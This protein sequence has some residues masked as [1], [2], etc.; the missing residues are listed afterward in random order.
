MSLDAIVL[1]HPPTR[2]DHSIQRTMSHRIAL[3]NR[4]SIPLLLDFIEEVLGEMVFPLFTKMCQYSVFS[5]NISVIQK[6]PRGGFWLAFLA[7]VGFEPTISRAWIWWVNHFSTPRYV[8]Y[9]KI[10]FK[11]H[12]SRKRL[13]ELLRPN[14]SGLPQNLAGAIGW[15]ACRKNSPSI[16]FLLLDNLVYFSTHGSTKLAN[17]D[18]NV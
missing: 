7:G 11:I 17:K 13:P 14:F 5:S 18:F 16:Y 15:S 3:T 8:I 4:R 6:A 2:L 1:A 9:P 10:I 12:S